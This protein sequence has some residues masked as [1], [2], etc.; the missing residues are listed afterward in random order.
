MNACV[1]QLEQVWSDY[2]LWFTYVLILRQ[3][4]NCWQTD[5]NN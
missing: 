3:M 1:Q 4:L 2:H 5:I